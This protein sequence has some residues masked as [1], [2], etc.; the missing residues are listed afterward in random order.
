M[1]TYF[2]SREMVHL[3]KFAWNMYF[4]KCLIGT[5]VMK[6]NNAME[7]HWTVRWLEK[8]RP[9]KWE[10]QYLRQT[11]FFWLNFCCLLQENMRSS[12]KAYIYLLF[13][14]FRLSFIS[15]D[16]HAIRL[17]FFP[18]VVDDWKFHE[19]IRRS[20]ENLW[21]KKVE[22]VAFWGAVEYDIDKNSYRALVLHEELYAGL[23]GR[24]TKTT[25]PLYKF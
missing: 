21:M 15:P 17:F 12:S 25:F 22:T 18:V 23:W 19:V 6:F 7:F 10:L 3:Y 8:E 2:S 20:T 1:S 16:I 9:A 14:L 5:I 13:S 24:W 4:Q 11:C